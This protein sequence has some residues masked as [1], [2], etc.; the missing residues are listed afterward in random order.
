[1][2]VGVGFRPRL[3]ELCRSVN[4]CCR[5]WCRHGRQ[6]LIA[7]PDSTTSASRNLLDDGVGRKTATPSSDGFRSRRM[8]S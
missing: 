6:A 1:V 5:Y 2:A 7:K 8:V 4:G 3:Q